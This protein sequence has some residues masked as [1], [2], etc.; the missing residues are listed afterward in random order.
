MQHPNTPKQN[1]FDRLCD[2]RNAKGL[3]PQQLDLSD[4]DSVPEDKLALVVRY[5]R[6]S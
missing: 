1:A 3:S 5:R 6:S 2:Y 4:G